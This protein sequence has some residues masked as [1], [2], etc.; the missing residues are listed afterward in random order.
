MGEC[1]FEPLFRAGKDLG[2]PGCFSV[3]AFDFSPGP[4]VVAR[5]S[6]E[7]IK[8]LDALVSL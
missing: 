6:F 5:K 4:E 3:E 1:D 7:T 2:F 8:R